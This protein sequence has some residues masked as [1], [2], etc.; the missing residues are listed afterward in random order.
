MTT[1]SIPRLAGNPR[2]PVTP[3]QNR[4]LAALPPA[5]LDRLLPGLEP[6]SIPLGA[7][8]YHPGQPIQQVYF[9]TSAIVSR[10]Y[11]TEAGNSSAIA[12]IGNEGMVGTFALMGSMTSPNQAVTF[13]AGTAYRMHVA[14]LKREFSQGGPL[15]QLLLRYVQAILTG[16]AQTAVCNRR[17]TVDQQLCRWLLQALDRLPSNQMSV[18]Q[19]SIASMIGVRRE[20][21]T[22]AAGALQRAGF[23]EYNRGQI[24]VLDR[25]ALEE[26]TCECYMVVRNEFDRLLPPQKPALAG[27]LSREAARHI[28]AMA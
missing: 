12:M 25:L 19:E 20:G 6:V 22:E 1:T 18:T 8:L 16:I 11:V 14:V 24:T 26:R 17:H 4:L 23:I 28:P 3:A 21:V 15:T 7:V 27:Q 2:S 5:V 9:P 13:S 10:T